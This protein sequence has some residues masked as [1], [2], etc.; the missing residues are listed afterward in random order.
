VARGEGGFAEDTAPAGALVA[1]PDGAG[2]WAVGASLDE[3]R[4]TAG[5]VQGRR[6]TVEAEPPLALPEGDW[7]VTLRT[8]WVEPAYLE[9]DA[10]WCEPGG[11]P[12]TPLANG[13]AFGAKRASPAPAAAR[14]LADEHGRAVRVVLSRED[15]VR[16]GAKRPPLAVGLRADGTGVVRVVRTPGIAAAIAAAAP[17]VAV[18]EV[19]VPGPPTSADLRGA[20]WA[21]LAAVRAAVGAEPGEPVTVTSPGGGRATVAVAPDGAVTA[22]VS[23][24]EVLDAVVLRSYVIGAVNQ[25]LGWVTSESLAVD[26]AGT[27]HDLTVR[28][29]G[30]VRAADMPP[31]AVRLD[32]DATG[33]PVNGSDAVLAAT[34][35]AVWVAQGRPPAW[36]TRLPWPPVR[37]R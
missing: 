14:A 6:T 28:S 34:A 19:E 2:G 24:G 5:K 7:A 23:C 15:A 37:P 32:E 29:F 17:G 22:A 18:E 11:E 13:G 1:V 12:A 21:E 36:P 35:A 25:A 16:F 8:S 27:V 30:V 9:T 10:S 31:V 26:G 3:A 4:A 20:G 33:T